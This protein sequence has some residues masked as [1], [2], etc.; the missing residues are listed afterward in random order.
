MGG[1]LDGGLERRYVR[2]LGQLWWL[3]NEEEGSMVNRNGAIDL[4]AEYKI[5][6]IVL[7][8]EDAL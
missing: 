4:R 7:E 6:I 1:G 5:V 2:V 3:V 8:D